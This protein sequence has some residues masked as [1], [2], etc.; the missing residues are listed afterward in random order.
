RSCVLEASTAPTSI[1]TC[2]RP[3]PYYDAHSA[4][5]RQ[6]SSSNRYRCNA[7]L[8]SPRRDPVFASS[9]KFRIS[10]REQITGVDD[11]R[12]ED[13]CGATGA[14]GGGLVRAIVADRAGAFT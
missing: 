12:E 13:H 14:Q 2:R 5:R 7:A 11:D 9:G 8:V 6:I 4:D 10:I 1:D 3:R